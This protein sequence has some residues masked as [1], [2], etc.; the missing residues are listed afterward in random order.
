[1]LVF[2]VRCLCCARARVCVIHWHCSAQFS[3]FNMEKRCRNKIIIIIII[4][5]IYSFTLPKALANDWNVRIG[6]QYIK[7]NKESDNDWFRLDCNKEGTRWFGKCWYIHELIKYEFDVEFDVSTS[8][9]V[10]SHAWG[11]TWCSSQYV[12]FVS[13]PPMLLHGYEFCLGLESLGFSGIFWSSSPEVFSGYS[14][15]LPS[16]IG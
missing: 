4:I 1:M 3:M 6:F 8:V 9:F 13:L 14:G 15:F 5:I 2:V 11:D 7:S 16:L 10:C 12:C